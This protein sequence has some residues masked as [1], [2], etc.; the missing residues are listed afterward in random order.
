MY[1]PK[2]VA[3]SLNL[4]STTIRIYSAKWA[5]YLSPAANPEAGQPR[6]YSEEDLA[7]LTTIA[8]LRDNQATAAHIRAALDAG[9]RLEPVRPVKEPPP[10]DRADNDQQAADQTRAAAAVAAAEKAVMIYQDRVNQLEARTDHLA[11]RLIDAE[12][13][14]AA[15]AAALTQLEAR[16]LADQTRADQLAN[17]LAADQARAAAAER[18]LAILRE[19]YEA[20][21]S[22]APGSTRPTFWQWLTGRK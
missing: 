3:D 16:A 10:A 6:Q 17:Q 7:V 11:D 22:P 21:T 2:Q 15:A 18:E 8:A 13:R 14:A 12:S 1:T 5:D 9:E 20:A 4:S 19:M